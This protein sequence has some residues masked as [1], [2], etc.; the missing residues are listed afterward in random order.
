MY[1]IWLEVN[2]KMVPQKWTKEYMEAMRDRKKTNL[3]AKQYTIANDYG[4]MILDELVKLYPAPEIDGFSK[5][6]NKI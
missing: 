1:L 2:G 4:N 5:E 6:R 3:I